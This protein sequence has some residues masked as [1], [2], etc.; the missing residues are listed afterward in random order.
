[1]RREAERWP[2][3]KEAGGILNEEPAWPPAWS[4]RGHRTQLILSSPVMLTRVAVVL[5]GQRLFG[6][7]IVARQEQGFQLGAEAD[8]SCVDVDGRLHATLTVGEHG[9][10]LWHVWKRER[11][12]RGLRAIDLPQR[13]GNV[14]W[15]LRE[16]GKA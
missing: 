4:F 15:G 7:Q 10:P 9:C 12:F 11:R 5:Q 16:K 8:S 6:R 2:L 3:P 1:M 14:G 13:M